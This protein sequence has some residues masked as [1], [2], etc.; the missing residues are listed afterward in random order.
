MLPQRHQKIG[1]EPWLKKEAFAD[2]FLNL[3]SIRTLLSLIE[4]LPGNGHADV[5]KRTAGQSA[6]VSSNDG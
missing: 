3:C 4:R 2:N 5:K 6:A 1:R